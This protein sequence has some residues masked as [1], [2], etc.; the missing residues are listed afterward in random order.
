MLFQF[1]YRNLC[2]FSILTK[3]I[4]PKSLQIRMLLKGLFTS[5]LLLVFTLSANSQSFYF[6]RIDRPY[7]ITGGLGASTFFGDMHRPSQDR[8]LEIGPS[9]SLGIMKRF[10][11][12]FYVRGEF[13]YYNIK[14]DDKNSFVEAKNEF[15]PESDRRGRNLV[16]FANNFELSTTAIIDFVPTKGYSYKVSRKNGR[17]VP[18]VNSFFRPSFTPYGFFGLAITTNTPKAPL[19]GTNYKLRP[20]R[21]EGVQY[22]AV[23]LSLPVG[24][25]L[26]FKFDY[27]ND[28]AIEG[29]YRF[30]FT[31]Y[32]D[33]VHGIYIDPANF[34]NDP[35]AFRLQDRRPEIGLPPKW[36]LNQLTGRSLRRG[37]PD[38]D[39][40][41]IFQVKWLHYLSKRDIEKFTQPRPRNT[42]R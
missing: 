7:I 37:D 33:D 26:K 39:G 17:L 27:K 2:L 18:T 41:F 21:T 19:D 30:T 4:L 25:G 8:P 35:I 34:A 38:N 6:Q 31:D 14:G 20:L 10:S 32:M 16:F 15:D 11:N 23:L 29:G 36:E 9:A 12:Q 24:F 42:F 22:G 1:L 3:L 13:N 28:I 5:L 40:Y